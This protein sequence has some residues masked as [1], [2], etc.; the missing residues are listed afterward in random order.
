MKIFVVLMLCALLCLPVQAGI[1]E[2][3]SSGIAALS[4]SP[5]QPPEPVKVYIDQAQAAAA[6]RNWTGVLF[7]T[8][9]GLTWYP[10]NA[11]LI[12]LQGYSYR[13]MGQ[14]IKSV[15]LISRGI[16]LD[17]KPVRYA[18]RGYGY[19]ALGN[20]SAALA[21]AETG[22]SIN[23]NYT[24]AYGVKAL[25]LQGLGKN[26]EALAAIDS[27]LARDPES[28]HYWHVKGRLLFAI[29]NCTGARESLE[30][31]LSL[32]PGYDLPYPGFPGAHEDL[33][34]LDARCAPAT[35]APT[36]PKSSTGGIAAAVVAITLVA[37]AVRWRS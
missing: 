24:T 19:I 18:N 33:A 35:P 5:D 31:S 13:K 30:R 21:D 28:A 9:Q 34:A 16:L 37:G 15:D 1:A 22:I 32:D 29:G 3:L 20:Y 8:T 12:C 27:A 4:A 7:L 6:G 17:P 23:A 25:A 10:D 11:D 36:T 26:T 14:S 2:P